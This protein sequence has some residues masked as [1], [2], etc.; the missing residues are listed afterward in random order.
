[1]HK[2]YILTQA[3]KQS[4]AKLPT[5]QIEADSGRKKTVYLKIDDI[6]GTWFS[7]VVDIRK[8][9]PQIGK[10][11]E[12]GFVGARLILKTNNVGIRSLFFEFRTTTDKF[13]LIEID[14]DKLGKFGLPVYRA[15]TKDNGVTITLFPYNLNIKDKDFG[16]PK[17]PP[18]RRTNLRQDK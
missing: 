6:D 10:L 15:L 16:Q 8:F 13:E 11:N 2:E 1:M 14:N 5:T 4:E 18:L 17:T 7:Q 9:N 12:E 3:Y